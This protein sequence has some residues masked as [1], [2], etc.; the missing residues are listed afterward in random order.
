MKLL[1]YGEPGREKPGL[2]D[3]EGRIRDLS[4][5]VHD[6]TPETL[7]N[8]LMDRLA[9]LDPERLP[10]VPGEHRLGPCVARPGKIVCIGLNYE[11]HAA[12]ANLER[13][14][15][16]VIFLKAPSALC[17]PTDP[18]VLPRGSSKVDWEVELGLVVGRAARHVDRE[19]ALGYLAG[20]C[21]VNDVTERGFQ[22][23]HNG[24]WTK[25]KSADGFCPTGPW[26]V[27][28][29]EV[30][31][32]QD[33]A[34]RLEV[35]GRAYQQG[36][37]ARMIFPVAEIIAY[38]SRFM[39]L[40]PGDLVATGTPAGVG[41]GQK[42]PVYLRPGNKVRATIDGLGEQRQTVVAADLADCA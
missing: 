21:I 3:R 15:E 10:I 5:I 26:L 17:G 27:T 37:T 39:S 1:R 20:Y 2:L 32:P 30:G 34:L 8:G 9:A 12:E 35:D 13:P 31:D 29:D 22:F 25:G 23:D 18:I 36:N 6:I 41:M 38:V 24:Q 40:Q 16:P 33:L 42:P 7:A 11:D 14:R 28:P 4:E 19:D